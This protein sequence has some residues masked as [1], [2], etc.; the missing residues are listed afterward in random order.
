MTTTYCLRCGTSRPASAFTLATHVEDACLAAREL[1]RTAMLKGPHPDL[2]RAIPDGP[3]QYVK[4]H[5]AR[6]TII[7]LLRD[8]PA[9]VRERSE[10]VKKQLA[11]REYQRSHRDLLKRRKALRERQA[12]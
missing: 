5:K 11:N 6:R 7:A 1:E 3:C 12:A 4:S 2:G 10:K 8:A 9:A